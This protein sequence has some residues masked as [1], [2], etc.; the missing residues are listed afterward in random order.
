MSAIGVRHMGRVLFVA[1]LILATTSATLRAQGN[2]RIHWGDPVRVRVACTARSGGS[3]CDTTYTT[4][5]VASLVADTLVLQ[6]DGQATRF[7]LQELEDLQI[8]VGRAPTNGFGQGALIGLG[9]GFL[10][11]AMVGAAAGSCSGFDLETQCALLGGAAFGVAGLLVGGTIG[12]LVANPGGWKRI[13]LPHSPGR[14]SR[15]PPPPVHI[16][17]PVAF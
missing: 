11:G 4:G 10:S 9:L 7:Q 17:I 13:R 12:F 15:R 6:N 5:L 1:A 14:S 16:G 2:A 3:P 8:W